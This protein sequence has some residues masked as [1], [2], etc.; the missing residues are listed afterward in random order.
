MRLATSF[1]VSP[2]ARDIRF[3]AEDAQQP[4]SS[5]GGRKAGRS[6]PRGQP[7]GLY[8]WTSRGPPRAEAEA[9]RGVPS[10]AASRSGSTRGRRGARLVPRRTQSGAF[11]HPRPAARALL[12]DVEGPASC[13]G[14][15][16]AGRSLTRGQPLGLYSRTSRGPPRAEA[17]AKRG[18]PSPAASRPFGCSRALSRGERAMIRWGVLPVK[19]NSHLPPW[20]VDTGLRERAACHTSG[21]LVPSPEARGL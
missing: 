5:R 9:K 15:R 17:D 20:T 8:S 1:M 21:P 2:H 7:L 12:T 6:L 16:K 18:V 13:R 10:P 3:P 19:G 14:G 11:P 4:A